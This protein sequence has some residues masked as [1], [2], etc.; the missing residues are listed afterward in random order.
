M[1]I[2]KGFNKVRH[3][4]L[5]PDPVSGLYRLIFKRVKC[6]DGFTGELAVVVPGD[7]AGGVFWLFWAVKLLT[8]Q[9][10]DG[11]GLMAEF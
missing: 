9:A 5:S 6:A 2:S 3:F 1:N 8:S 4:L 11:I 10:I 7:V